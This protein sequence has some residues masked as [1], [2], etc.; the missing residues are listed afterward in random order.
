M[1]TLEL[2]RG[3]VAA[4]MLTLMFMM[5]FAGAVSAQSKSK[6]EKL[7]VTGHVVDQKSDMTMS[8]ITLY[9]Y[10]FKTQESVYM[11]QTMVQG[12]DSFKFK[13]DYDGEYMIEFAANNGVNKR[14][15][16]STDVAEAYRDTKYKFDFELDINDSSAEENPMAAA[17]IYFDPQET[18]FNFSAER[19]LTASLDQ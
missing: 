4:M 10:N 11:N 19:P 12:N 5:I 1:K 18:G 16:V 13:L 9:K 2:G 14:V 7:V 8:L 6:K 15:M 3:Q 17:F